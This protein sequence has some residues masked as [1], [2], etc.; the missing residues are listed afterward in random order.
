VHSLV[1]VIGVLAQDGANVSSSFMSSLHKVQV[2][3]YTGRLCPSVHPYVSYLKLLKGF[4]LNLVL[5]ANL[6][7]FHTG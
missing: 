5:V 7:F 3:T 1:D 4:P 2:V 6:N